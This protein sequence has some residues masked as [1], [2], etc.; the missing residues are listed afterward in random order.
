MDSS[1]LELRPLPHHY[2]GR[3]LE[4]LTHI[5]FQQR[6][7]MLR[8]TLK[9]LNI[10]DMEAVLE[11]LS[12]SPTSRPEELSVATFMKLAERLKPY[13]TLKTKTQNVPRPYNPPEDL[14]Q[15]FGE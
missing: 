2:D 11:A 4:A 5:V 1:I 7:K 10:P 14:P 13:L 9:P 12:I 6:R 8:V 15:E 3:A